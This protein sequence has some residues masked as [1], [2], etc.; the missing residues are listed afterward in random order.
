MT[1]TEFG[2]WAVGAGT[3]AGVL[4]K[5][6]DWA[7]ARI[8]THASERRKDLSDILDKYREEVERLEQDI[9]QEREACEVRIK[10]LSEALDGERTQ[11]LQIERVIFMMGWEK[12]PDGTGYQR[13]PNGGGTP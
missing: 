6:G 8:G 5:V 1:P 13:G 11:R 12:R 4:I 3:V 9:N 10:K 7:L 2:L